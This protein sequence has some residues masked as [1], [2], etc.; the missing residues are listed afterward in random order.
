M[1]F[2]NVY[3]ELDKVTVWF[4]ENIRDPL[5]NDPT[6]VFATIAFRWFNYI[7]TGTWLRDVN[8]FV[9]WDTQKVVRLLEQRK[10][11][12]KQI[13]TG[14][15]NISNSGSTKPK[16]NRVCE[17]YI[18]PVWER[19]LQ[20]VH[21]LS[22]L[23]VSKTSPEYPCS[24]AGAFNTLSKLPGLGGSGFMAAQ[25]I[26]DLKHTF[27]L[28]NAPDWWTWCSPGPGSIRGLN[29][30]L[31]R[32]VD[33]PKPANFLEEINK[34]QEKLSKR[35]PKMPRLCAQDTQNCLCEYSKFCRALEG[36]HSKR[37]YPGGR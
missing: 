20:I 4:R 37:K 6:V 29:I 9:E 11:L 1:Y 15:F 27:V 16:I 36:G 18:Q 19:K 28:E 21:L 7:P 31:G 10:K 23:Q 17:D 33:A 5:R 26:A 25:V 34:L 30:L 14:A 22:P 8:A 12:G 13:F 3:R 24:L 32:P 2:T 35:L